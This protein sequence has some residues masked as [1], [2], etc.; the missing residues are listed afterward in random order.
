M[1]KNMG[2]PDRIIRILAAIVFAVL[3]FTGTVTGTWGIVLLVLGGVFVLT[4][5]IGFCPLYALVGMNTCPVKST[6][7]GLK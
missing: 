3:Y 2:S 6:T 5:F 4:S 1:K 7:Q